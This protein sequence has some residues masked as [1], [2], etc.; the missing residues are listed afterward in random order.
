MIY[1]INF[2]SFKDRLEVVNTLHVWADGD[3]V[4]NPDP[5]A[6]QVADE[7]SGHLN[8]QYRGMLGAEYTLDRIDCVTVTDP[9]QPSQVPSAGSH[10]VQSPGLHAGSNVDLPPRIGGMVQWRTGN[11]GRSFTG[12]FFC[13]PLENSTEIAADLITAGGA[14]STAVNLFTG[15]VLDGSLSGGGSWGSLWT[16]TWHGYFG[17][18]SPTRH[19]RGEA[20]FLSRIT[21]AT[22]KR[23]LA[24]LSSRDS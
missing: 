23:H 24:Y 19:K 5:S 8:L 9:N 20:P 15:T 1:R 7:V 3:F 10:S 13:P 6:Q 16:D 14:Y 4:S 22:Y 21:G 11:V 18:Y 17:V 2:V 12:R